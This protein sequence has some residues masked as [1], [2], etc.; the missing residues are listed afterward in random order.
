[1]AVC[2]NIQGPCTVTTRALY[3]HYKRLVAPLQGHCTDTTN[4]FVQMHC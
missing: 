2:G 1:M 4:G 3:E